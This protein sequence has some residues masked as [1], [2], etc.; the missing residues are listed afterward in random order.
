MTDLDKALVQTIDSLK[1]LGIREGQGLWP[2]TN[3]IAVL[4]VQSPMGDLR[5]ASVDIE[6]APPVRER[7]QEGS[8]VFVQTVLI[9]VLDQPQEKS[10]QRDGQP[11][12]GEQVKDMIS[13]AMHIEIFAMTDTEEGVWRIYR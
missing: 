13:D 8:R 7:G 11:V 10:R 1:S 4:L 2:K 9:S 5:P 3:N 12:L 6:E